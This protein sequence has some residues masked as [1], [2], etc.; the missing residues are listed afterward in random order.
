MG[1]SKINLLMRSKNVLAI[2]FYERLFNPV[3]LVFSTHLYCFDEEPQ[4]YK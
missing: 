3:D 1:C 2:A 4:R